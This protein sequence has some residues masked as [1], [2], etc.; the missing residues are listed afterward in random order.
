MTT[1]ARLRSSEA[2]PDRSQETAAPRLGEFGCIVA[3]RE[4]RTGTT[5][6]V[7]SPFDDSRVAVV[8]RAGRAEIDR[9]IAAARGAFAITR[10]LPSWK[11]AAILETI[12]ATIAS[13]RDELAR[14]I[15]LEAGK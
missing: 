7:R 6:D 9:A 3:G 8:H 12:S 10:A 1:T 14:T 2:T 11:R 15:A 5:I 4:V 13:R